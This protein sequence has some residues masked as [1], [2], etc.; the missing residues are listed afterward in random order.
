MNFR[1][2]LQFL[3]TLSLGLPVVGLAAA[4]PAPPNIV[5]ILADDMGWNEV[6]Y[7]GSTY[8]ETPNIDR[9]ARRGVRFTDAYSAA[10]ICSP[11]RA[12]LMTGKYPARLHLTDYIPGRLWEDKPL[13]TPK[14][15][16]GLP[17]AEHT[18]PER[19]RQ[20]GYATGLF[21]KWHLAADYEYRPHRP[22]DPE[23]QGFDTV[24]H[25]RKPEDED[26]TAKKPDAHNAVE[27]TDHALKFIRTHRARPFFCYVAHNVVHRPYGEDD[28]LVEKYR[29]KSGAGQPEN[30]AVMAAMIERMDRQIG[31]LLDALE[32]EGLADRTLVV[33]HSDNGAVVADASQAP[34]RGGKATLWE[35]GIRVPLAIH[36]PGVTRSG[37]V[38]KEPVVT[39]DLFFTLCEAAGAPTNDLPSDGVSLVSHLRTGAPLA[40]EAIYFHYPHY[41]H[42]GDMRPASVIRAGSLKLIE[43]H[44][45][46][47]LGRGPVVSLFDLA[48]DPGEQ[49]D[50]ATAQTA[51][52][53]ELRGKLRRW[54]AAVGAQE[55]TVR[56]PL[57]PSAPR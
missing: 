1:P 9:L 29:R 12:A 19:L 52:A 32:S 16:Q 14:M 6:G 27:I 30:H 26:I 8:Y 31:R 2:L 46:A 3:R 44:E 37:A 57:P 53:N 5:F 50:L 35:G 43:W 11:T 23:S 54:R 20:R 48:A 7:H 51:R 21:G 4:V 17:L 22:M 28:A 49:N 33:F 39:T 15:Q 25:T 18:L 36:W 55:M 47:L 10:A 42:L 41:H 24:F 40:R 38:S 56:K 45:G 34:F 13:V